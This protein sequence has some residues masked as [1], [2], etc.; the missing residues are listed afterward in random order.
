[1]HVYYFNASSRFVIINNTVIVMVSIII[2][3]FKIWQK[4]P[5]TLTTF[6]PYT[7]VNEYVRHAPWTVKAEISYHIKL[8]KMIDWSCEGIEP[9]VMITNIETKIKI[10]APD[11]MCTGPLLRMRKNTHG[12]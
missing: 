1:M 6:L 8:L 11:G 3:S 12:T 7:R 9:L 4:Y 2:E 10:H 5:C